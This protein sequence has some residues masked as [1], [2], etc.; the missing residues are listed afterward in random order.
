MNSREAKVLTHSDRSRPLDQ[1]SEMLV[2]RAVACFPILANAV[3]SA[4]GS[5]PSQLDVHA[6]KIWTIMVGWCTY[7]IERACNIDDSQAEMDPPGEY[8]RKV[9]APIDP[10]T[11]IE[12]IETLVVAVYHS[13]LVTTVFCDAGSVERC[14]KARRYTL[15]VLLHQFWCACASSP[16][17]YHPHRILRVIQAEDRQLKGIFEDSLRCHDIAQVCSAMVA[18]F[19]HICDNMPIGLDREVAI[20][21]ISILRQLFEYNHI[22]SALAQHGIGYWMARLLRKTTSR[23]VWHAS[24]DMRQYFQFF[25][26]VSRSIVMLI[27]SETTLNF[28]RDMLRGG[29]II[30]I[31]NAEYMLQYVQETMPELSTT[32]KGHTDFLGEYV[33]G[34]IGGFL[35]WPSVRSL[36]SSQ[37][38]FS[39]PAERRLVP[40]EELEVD[41]NKVLSAWLDMKSWVSDYKGGRYLKTVLTLGRACANRVVWFSVRRICMFWRC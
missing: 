20:P 28:V 25:D 38:K 24:Q 30:A 10:N 8:V 29:I 15:A 6:L 11:W 22:K 32:C 36:V 3:S 31:L 1:D 33:I 7:L 14:E 16:L 9:D 21:F 18:A 13:G 5:V 17:L 39:I 2:Q 40:S 34:T 37:A 19:S 4:T 27:L 12:P 41:V 23:R 35:V 26:T